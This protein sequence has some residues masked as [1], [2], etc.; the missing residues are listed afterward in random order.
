[1]SHDFLYV[2]ANIRNQPGKALKTIYKEKVRMENILNFK[3]YLLERVAILEG[4]Q[5]KGSGEIVVADRI[6]DED[7]QQKK[8]I[9]YIRIK[10]NAVEF[11]KS[12]PVDSVS[13][14]IGS[15]KNEKPG[16]YFF[17]ERSSGSP[18]EK[19]FFSPEQIKGNAY[20]ILMQIYILLFKESLQEADLEVLKDLVESIITAS[21][22]VGLENNSFQD[23]VNSIKDTKNAEKTMKEHG[24]SLDSSA[25]AQII[26]TVSSA[27][28]KLG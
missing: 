9:P 16:V 7:F 12:T 10:D 21:K 11:L 8:G 5:S 23:F 20:D 15:N 27:L 17:Q 22:K 1:L 26:D 24:K 14:V 3:S 6:K 25:K 13:L 19:K 4:V 18:T 2:N 28:K